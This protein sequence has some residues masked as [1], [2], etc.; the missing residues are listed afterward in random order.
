[1][2]RGG[3]RHCDGFCKWRV[4]RRVSKWQQGPSVP[5]RS[6]GHLRAPSPGLALPPADLPPPTPTLHSAHMCGLSRPPGLL[7]TQ[8]LVPGWETLKAEPF[9]HSWGHASLPSN[10]SPAPAPTQKHGT[11][12]RITTDDFF[13]HF[14]WTSWC[15]T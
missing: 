4:C 5:V 6:G 2:R 1:M 3:R 10:A 8:S 15:G 11:V 14:P 13:S 9:P 12:F 7:S